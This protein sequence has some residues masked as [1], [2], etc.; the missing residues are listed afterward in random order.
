MKHEI[1]YMVTPDLPDPATRCN[2]NG[3]D[4][5][6]LMS[7]LAEIESCSLTP[8]S[9]VP[10]GRCPECNSL[11]Y[12]DNDP[13]DRLAAMLEEAKS[14]RWKNTASSASLRLGL[15][16]IIDLGEYKP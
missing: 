1:D 11:A 5:R 7:D 2:C 10:A 13:A 14:W 15:S 8:G 9:I 6:G 12:A 3:C 16:R 4:W